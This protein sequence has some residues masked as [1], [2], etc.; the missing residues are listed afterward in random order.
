MNNDIPQYNNFY[1]FFNSPTKAEL[2]IFL[3]QNGWVTRKE[4]W[5]DFECA[6]DWSE[7]YLHGDD[8]NPLLNGTIA[9]SET[10][11]Q[12]L[13]DLFCSINAKFQTEL[14]DKDKTLLKSDKI[15]A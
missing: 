3:E 9:N 5:N 1:S 10:N 4:S 12:K 2:K 8:I 15:S 6:N 14:Y 11:Y 13:I 7:L